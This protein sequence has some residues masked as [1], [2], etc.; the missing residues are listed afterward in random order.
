MR[1]EIDDEQ[2]TTRAQH[3]PSFTQRSRWIV[4]VMQH[5]MQND[6]IVAVAL[7]RHGVDVALPELRVA[8]S[9]TLQAGTGDGEHRRGLIDADRALGERRQQFQHAA[10]AGAEIEQSMDWSGADDLAQRRLDPL[11]R[12]M[13]RTDAVPVWRL[14][15]EIAGG[16]CIAGAAHL[17]EP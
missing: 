9:G 10:G 8:Q 16:L 14:R 11:F 6:E 2:T 5:L 7:D 1:G 12:G 15:R 3:A 13:E 17:S 4:E